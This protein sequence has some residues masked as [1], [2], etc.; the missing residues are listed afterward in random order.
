MT[1]G[2]LTVRVALLL[3]VVKVRLSPFAGATPPAQLLLLL[4]VALLVPDQVRF[5]AVAADG[6]RVMESNALAAATSVRESRLLECV[7]WDVREVFIFG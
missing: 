1:G 6:R 4:Q 3:S 5:A 2:V 7:C